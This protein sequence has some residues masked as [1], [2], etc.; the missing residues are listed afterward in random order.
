M[1]QVEEEGRWKVGPSIWIETKQKKRKENK[2]KNVKMTCGMVEESGGK[3]PPLLINSWDEDQRRGGEK[4]N[5][6]EKERRKEK[7]R[8]EKG[9]F[10]GI[11]TVQELKTVHATR[12]TCGC[13]NLGV[14]SNSKR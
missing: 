4:E 3:L 5:R 14:L 6:I 1:C 2:E 13:Q 11:L 10:L 8:D 9:N 7:G 12:A